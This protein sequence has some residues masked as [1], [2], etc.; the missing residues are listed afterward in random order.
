MFAFRHTLLCVGRTLL[1]GAWTCHCGQALVVE[2]VVVQCEL[3]ALAAPLLRVEEDVDTTLDLVIEADR[4]DVGRSAVGVVVAVNETTWSTVLL[5]PLAYDFV[6]APV[7]VC[8]LDSSQLLLHV[9]DFCVEDGEEGVY[10]IVLVNEPLREA[11]RVSTYHQKMLAF[12]SRR[13][14]RC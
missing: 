8:Q 1:N 13:P 9:A 7:A 10:G 12:G 11:F 2:A 4:L 14:A 3:L 5:D 6:P